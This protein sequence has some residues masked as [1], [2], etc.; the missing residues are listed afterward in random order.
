[1]LDLVMTDVFVLVELVIT[2]HCLTAVVGIVFLNFGSLSNS[3]PASDNTNCRPLCR[4]DVISVLSVSSCIEMPCSFSNANVV[5]AFT[6]FKS[7]DEL[8]IV[9]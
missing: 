3:L 2:L 5:D 8:S 6:E 9:V 4:A 7:S 1:M